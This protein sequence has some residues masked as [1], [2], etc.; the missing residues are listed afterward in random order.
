MFVV[1]CSG[2][3]DCASGC[4]CVCGEGLG[5]SAAGTMHICVL[6]EGG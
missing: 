3:M 2:G 6:W 5:D 4:L 1:Y